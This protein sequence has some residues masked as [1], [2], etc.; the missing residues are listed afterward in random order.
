[1]EKQKLRAIYRVGE[2]QMRAYYDKASNSKAVTGEEMI[3]QL[4]TRLDTVVLAVSSNS[5]EKNAQALK[6]FGNLPVE[7]LS[8]DNHANSHRFQSY[9]DFED[10]EL[11]STILIDKLGRVYWG[12]NG[13]DPFSDMTF[14]V[15][16]LERMN[17][18]VVHVAKR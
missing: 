11:H 10:I 3:R 4:E 9:D 13:G 15:K 12:R 5:P 8:D 17:D 2:K 6:S 14:L 16:Q 7:L 18:S 1:M